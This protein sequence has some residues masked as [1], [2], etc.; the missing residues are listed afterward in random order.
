[1]GTLFTI[2]KDVKLQVELNPAKVKGYRLIGKENWAL[3]DKNFNDEKKNAGNLGDGHS[4]T[5]LYEFIPA[6]VEDSPYLKNVDDL[7]YQEIRRKP[8]VEAS[9]EILTLKL[10]YKTP[11]GNKSKLM[12]LP[13]EDNNLATNK[14]S[15]D[16]R[17]SAAVAAFGMVLRD[18]EFKGSSTYASA[19]RLANESKGADEEGYRAEFINLIKAS[20]LI[21][22]N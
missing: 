2:A 10:R 6:S 22:G 12:E 21:S 4:V 3:N 8:I 9:G 20:Q 16:Y 11:D 15:D 19:L 7:K 1:G 13:V 5:A 14:T 18:S 17:F